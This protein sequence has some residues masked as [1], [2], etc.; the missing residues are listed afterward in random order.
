MER[1]SQKWQ[2]LGITETLADCVARM[3]QLPAA[4]DIVRLAQ[5]GSASGEK[6]SVDDVATVYFTID[7]RLGLA[8]IRSR[9]LALPRDDRWDALARA[10]LRDDLA[11]EHAALTAV[12]LAANADVAPRERLA[13]WAAQHPRTVERHLAV[14]QEIQES[15]VS[16]VATMSVVLREL[17]GLAVSR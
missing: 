6:W 10:A 1:R 17:R 13:S 3:E 11:T 15:A 4:L 7:D 16:N 9:I 14:T 8:A 12:V 2:A 5:Q